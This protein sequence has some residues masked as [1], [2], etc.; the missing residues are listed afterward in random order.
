[1]TARFNDSTIRRLYV[2]G[3]VQVIMFPMENDSTYN[4]FVFTESSTMDAYFNGNE[5]E[6]INMWPETTGKA[7]PLYRPNARPTICPCSAGMSLCGL[8]HPP[9]SSTTPQRWPI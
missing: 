5:I 8:W 2:E 6:K 7:T 3:N 4:K 1:M 9:K